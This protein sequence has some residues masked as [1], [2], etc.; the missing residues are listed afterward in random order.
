ML[1][2]IPASHFQSY[3][4]GAQYPHM[5]NR[6]QSSL[7][8]ISPPYVNSRL[9][10][11]SSSL[12]SF[13][14]SMLPGCHSFQKEFY[15]IPLVRGFWMLEVDDSLM[16]SVVPHLFLYIL[17]VILRFIKVNWSLCFSSEVW[18]YASL[19]VSFSL[20]WRCL[21]FAL[22]FPWLQ[23]LPLGNQVC[24]HVLQ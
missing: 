10:G 9:T 24:K 12:F 3:V 18:L 2:C 13:S 4:E 16:I 14:A 21:E 17:L 1:V 11:N 7:D 22:W 15:K 23:M 20:G 6:D 5:A 8:T 19:V